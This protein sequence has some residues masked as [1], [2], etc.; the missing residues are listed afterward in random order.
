M[1]RREPDGDYP[2]TG[3]G[4]ELRLGPIIEEDVAARGAQT[5]LRSIT[6]G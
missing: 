3:T 6:H 2:F 4:H 5:A 1:Q